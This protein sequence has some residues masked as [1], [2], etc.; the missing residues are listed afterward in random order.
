MF[1]SQVCPD[2]MK[3]FISAADANSVSVTG[4]PSRL[5]NAFHHSTILRYSKHMALPVYNGLCHAAHLYTAHDVKTI[6][7]VSEEKA[8]ALVCI[9]V[10]SAETGKSLLS[11]RSEDLWEEI[12]MEILAKGI[13]LDNLT[14][15]LIR[16][17]SM[18][19][20]LEIEVI[21][22]RT[23]LIV[24]GL[25]SSIQSN[26]PDVTL[27]RRDIVDWSLIEEPDFFPSAP[28]SP[29]QSKLAIVGMACRLPGG[30]ND[31]DLFW[32]LIE[33]GRD[34]H[35][36]IPADRFDIDTHYDPTGEIPNTTQTPFG[37]FIDNPGMF[38]ANFFN[39]SPREVRPSRLEAHQAALISNTSS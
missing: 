11:T 6:V 17:L 35:T 24:Q 31:L 21:T 30:A 18:V 37:N 25:L 12:V 14:A 32:K 33:E 13:Y 4:P 26:L 9:P 29:H 8:S 20:S 2:L 5:I 15:G 27:P 3:V 1:G 7:I 36:R 10:L 16:E 34:V 28:R 39:M 19:G 22:L 38:D 23:S